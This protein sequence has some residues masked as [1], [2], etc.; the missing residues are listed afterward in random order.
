MSAIRAN[1]RGWSVSRLT[2]KTRWIDGKG[3]KIGDFLYKNSVNNNAAL[4]EIKKPQ[5][6][7]V[8]KY[9]DGVYGPHDDLSGGV[10]QV[11]DQRYHFTRKFPLHQSDNDWHGENEV[12]DYE[13]DCVLIVG[14]MPTEKDQRRSFHLYRKNSHGV[15]IVTFDEVLEMLKSLVTY[16]S[17]T[18]FH[19]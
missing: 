19:E 6:S 7:V 2:G 5:S 9:R 18:R 12:A 16:L 1:I 17:A 14:T 8:K 13:V 4:I 3:E 10:T 15:R 11:L